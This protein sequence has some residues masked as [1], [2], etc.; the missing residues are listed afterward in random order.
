MRNLTVWKFVLPPSGPFTLFMPVGS[1]A[2]RGIVLRDGNLIFYALVD[3]D[4]P[5]TPRHFLTLG[6]G[7]ITKE[8][9]TFSY[10]GTGEPE[11]GLWFH[12]FEVIP[13]LR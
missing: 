13:S 6:T 10:I 9:G 1:Q 11:P 2:L 12:V 5:K 8:T 3:P 7:E 4:A